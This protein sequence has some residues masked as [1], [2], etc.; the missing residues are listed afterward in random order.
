MGACYVPGVGPKHCEGCKSEQGI[1][2][3]LKVTVWGGKTDR[4]VCIRDVNTAVSWPSL[5]LTGSPSS[6]A[7]PPSPCTLCCIWW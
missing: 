2:P 7:M 3:T 4:Q 1:V 5:A 6:L